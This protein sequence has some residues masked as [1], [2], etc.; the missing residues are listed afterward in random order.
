MKK[1]NETV[2]HF[3]LRVQQLVKKGWR[4]ESAATINLKNN[5][6]FTKGL[7]KKLKDFAHKRQVKHVSTIHEAS[8]PFHTLVR[9]VDS[10]IANEKIRTND[11][12]LETNKVLHK[13]NHSISNCYQKQRDDEYQ[14]HKNQRSKT[15]QQS[16]VQYFRSKPVIRKKI[17][18]KLKMSTFP[19]MMNA[20]KMT[21]TIIPITMVDIVV[22]AETTHKKLID[23]T[24]DED[25]TIDLQ[26]HTHLDP[27]M[28][29]ISKEEPHLD[30]HIDHQI[31]ETIPIIDTFLNQDIDLVLNHKEIPSNDTIIHIDLHQDQEIIDQDLEH[32]HKT[33]NKTE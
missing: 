2:R 25:I 1:D 4:N 14:K 5:E 22:I 7:P 3:A 32:P 10:D 11:L 28:T 24:L 15:P 16:F 20:T 33:D 21:K 13:S 31:T 29:I 8:I 17:N 6:I 19:E 9:L 26:V 27:D 12:A 23:Q 30:L 18:M